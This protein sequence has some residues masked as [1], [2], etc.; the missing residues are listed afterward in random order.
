MRAVV[1]EQ[2]GAAN[3]LRVKNVAKPEP[4]ASEVRI[5]V[6]AVEATKSDCE[7]RAMSFPVTW[8]ALPL[9]LGLGWSKLRNP[10]LG[11]YISGR[12]DAVGS[13]VQHFKLGDEV[14]GCTGFRFGG[15]AEYVCVPESASLVEKPKNLSFAQAAAIPLG[16]I[17]ALH[18]MRAA[19]IAAGERVLILG[20]AGSIGSFAIQLAKQAG[21]HVTAVEAP[22]KLG[23]VR[24]LGADVSIDY[25]QKDALGEAQRYD[26][27]FSTIA[28]DHYDR[29]LDALTARGRYLTA[30]PRFT[31]L[32]RSLWT[33]LTSKKRVVVAFAQETREELS[34]L[35]KLA[36]QGAIRPVLD[37]VFPIEGAALAHI[38]VETEQRLGCVVLQHSSAS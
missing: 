6:E 10:V 7:I 35:R 32:A 28:G 22:H 26:V 21:A 24:E 18:F 37:G 12:V 20:A 36:E 14:Y 27:I 5:R 16:G 4:G 33:N 15:Y 29:C 38:R 19:Q 11:A 34:T 23:L 13:T 1:C 25:T 17:N 30:N 31:D 9:R 3:V 2:Y 8:F